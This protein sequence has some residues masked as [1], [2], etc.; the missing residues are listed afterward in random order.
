MATQDSF[1]FERYWLDR[2]SDHLERIAG[3]A[4]R[5]AVME[6][7]EGLSDQAPRREVIQWSKFAIE[8]LEHLLDKEMRVK[9]MTGCA[10]QYPKSDLED[11]RDLYA[12][13]GD[14]ALAHQMLQHKF[15]SFLRSDLRLGADVIKEIVRRGW[16]LAGIRDGSTIIA[17]KI[18]KSGHLVQY[19]AETDPTRRRQLYCHCPR[20]RDVLRSDHTISAT[21]CYCGAGYYKGIWE[22]IIQ[23]PVEVEVLESVITGGETCRIEISL[24]VEE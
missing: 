24:P 8:R 1:D 4:I 16:G 2:L 14:L 15:E 10:C 11:V 13:T 21:Y 9:I 22:N 5:E 3:P 7:S 23:K 18:P 12:A 17:T 20:V 6:G 19:M